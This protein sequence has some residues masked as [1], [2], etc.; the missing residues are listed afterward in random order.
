[1]KTKAQI[2]EILNNPTLEGVRMKQSTVVYELVDAEV[3]FAKSI[4]KPLNRYCVVKMNK[5]I[6]KDP[7]LG[8]VFFQ[9]SSEKLQQVSRGDKI[10]LSI[11]LTG[12]GTPSEKYPDPIIFAKASTR[13]RDCVTIKKSV[14]APSVDDDLTVNV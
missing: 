11:N 10:S 3:V 2:I 7:I 1:M 13:K 6:V 8:S 9:S 5:I 14:D 4:L 12:V